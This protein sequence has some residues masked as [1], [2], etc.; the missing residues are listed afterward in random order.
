MTKALEAAFA[1]VAQIPNL[2]QDVLTAL[3]LDEIKS[4]R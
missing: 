3:L 1:E 4:E 2:E